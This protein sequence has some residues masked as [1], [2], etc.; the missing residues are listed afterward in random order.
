MVGNATEEGVRMEYPYQ[1]ISPMGH[2]VASAPSNCRYPKN[3]ELDMLEAGYTV[4]LNGKKITKAEVR[5]E[6]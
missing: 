1:V 3:I 5:K 6:R 4:R 2:I